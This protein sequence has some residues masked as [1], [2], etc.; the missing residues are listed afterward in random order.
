MAH[1][2]AHLLVDYLTDGNYP[3]WLTEGVA[4]YVESRVSGLPVHGQF[5]YG[6]DELYTLE[7]LD[8]GF[9][10]LPDQDLAYWQSW[11]LA[12]FMVERYGF[13]SLQSLLHTLGQGQNL[14][15]ALRRSLGINLEQFSNLFTEHL[16]EIQP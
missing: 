3:R 12:D 13:H 8:R 5:D 11:A 15:Q 14:D 9:D 16:K 4:Q 2:Y 6:V 1:E 10:S 7:E